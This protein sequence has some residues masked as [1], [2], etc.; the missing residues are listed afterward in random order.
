MINNCNYDSIDAL[1]NALNKKQISAVEIAKHYLKLIEQ[2]SDLNCFLDINYD[3]TMQQAKIADKLIHENKNNT[4]TG[5]PIAHKDIFVTK[6]W[7][8]TAASKMLKNYISPFDATVVARLAN[9][10]AVSLGKLNCDEFAMG[11][12][13]EN[14]AYGS[15]KNPWDY[16]II[17]GG[18]SGGAASAIAAGLVLAATA[19]DTGGSIRQPSSI[20]GISGIK[21][22]YG[23][24]SRFGMIAFSSSFD[25]AGVM[26]RSCKDLLSV[27]DNI[28]GFDK[29]D[30]TSLLK[31]NNKLNVKGRIIEDF[32]NSII[33]FQKYSSLPLKN[34]KI[35]IPIELFNK[36]IDL[37][38]NH[39]IKNAINEFEKLGAIIVD[40][41]LPNINLSVPT[42]YAITCSEASSNLARYDG[43][44]FGYRSKDFNNLDDMISKSRSEGFGLEVKKRIILGTYILSDQNFEKY[45][46]KSQKIRNIISQDFKT[47]F[48]SKCDIIICPV[49]EKLAR[50]FKYNTNNSDDWL[51]DMYTLGASLAG[52][53][54]LS[55]PCGFSSKNENRKSLPIG[56]QII[57]KPFSEGFALAIGDTYQQITNWHKQQ[58]NWLDTL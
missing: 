39:A 58:P 55:I 19:S 16:E 26:A 6:D 36:N 3:S 45:F 12:S 18:S 11:S 25:Q 1:K 48:D 28:S 22:T 24:V 44:K 32:N 43:V 5:I 10:G 40:V 2:K 15:V 27:I 41:S 52:L 29:N 17:P 37:D 30:Y 50:P 49:N 51:S 14:S 33:N 8:T 53:P 13:N 9:E 35:G 38:I 31:C 7:Y 46:L 56:M 47:V 4:L 20:C 21:P 23:T 57:G 42:Y 34:L 54:A